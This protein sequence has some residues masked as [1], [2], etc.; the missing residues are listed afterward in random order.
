MMLVES[1]SIVINKTQQNHLQIYTLKQSFSYY[2]FN[3][4]VA[5]SIFSRFFVSEIKQK[6]KPWSIC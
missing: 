4:V 1:N 3:L 6:N 5:P 2:R